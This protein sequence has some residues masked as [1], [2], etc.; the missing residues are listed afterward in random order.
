MGGE[1]TETETEINW[2]SLYIYLL[3]PD[4]GLNLLK[5]FDFLILIYFKLRDTENQQLS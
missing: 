2:E 5:G 1:R 4:S 3:F